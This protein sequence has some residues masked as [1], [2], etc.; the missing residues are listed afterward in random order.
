MVFVCLLVQ[1]K[2]AQPATPWVHI[3]ELHAHLS[4]VHGRQMQRFVDSLT[5]IAFPIQFETKTRGPYCLTVPAERVRFDVEASSVAAFIRTHGKGHV[6]PTSPANGSR[7][8]RSLK[9]ESESDRFL[10]PLAKMHLA[11]W[12]FHDGNLDNGPDHA[13]AIFGEL[14]KTEDTELKAVA[15]LKFARVCCRLQRF[16]ETQEALRLLHR[17]I[18]DGDV[19]NGTT[20]DYKGKMC[21]AALRCEQGRFDEARAITASLDIHNCGDETVQGE[22]QNLMGLL[23]NHDMLNCKHQAPD[24]DPRNN[25]RELLDI[26]AQHFRQALTIMV[27]NNNYSPMQRTCLNMG[28]LYI[29]A[30]NLRF[31][32]QARARYLSQGIRWIVHCQLLCSK[33][34]VGMD[35]VLSNIALIQ[36]AM[37]GGLELSDLNKLA[38]GRFK[39]YVDLDELASATLAEAVRIGNVAEQASTLWILAKLA[40]RKNDTIAMEEYKRQ[41]LAIYAKQN[42]ADSAGRMRRDLAEEK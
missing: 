40:K 23:V 16:E 21:L 1:K 11:D 42:R 38:N 27:R 8:N 30:S 35:S 39:S 41:A 31:P 17:M 3:K 37:S 9:A 2:L 19:T 10:A 28:N 14:I 36:A 12:Q 5:K 24:G 7:Q 4:S 22:Y 20:L 32:T 25:H 34:G 6:P 29:S 13:Y 33:F 15:L 18:R 26:A